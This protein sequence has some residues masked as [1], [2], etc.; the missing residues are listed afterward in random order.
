M[1]VSKVVLAKLSPTME[2]GTIVKWTK[3]EGDA[4]K[5]GDVLAEIETDKANMEMEAQGSGVLRKILVQAGGKA[6]IGTLIG[7]IAEA[8]EDIEP[9]IAKE[10]GKAGAAPKPA[11]TPAPAPAAP[12]PEPAKAAAEATAKAA[13]A[14]Q[15]AS[16]ASAAKTPPAP[17]PPAPGPA[18]APVAASAS[19]STGGDGG[20]VK[21]SPLARSMAAH[22]N[23]DLSSVAGSGPGGRII[24]RDIES[25]AGP[26]PSAAPARSS[27]APAARASSAPAPR[28]APPGPSITPGQ[29]LPLSN[30]RK[31]IAKRLSESKFGAPHYYV[32]VEIDMDAAVD[33]RDQIQ[34]L[35][36]GKVS[37]N[38]LVVKA[39]ARALTRFPMVNASWGGD[40]I[41]THADVN[42]GIAVA[43]PDGLITPVVRN[44]DRKSILDIAQEVRDL[45]TRARD[46][47]LKPEEF[48][49]S[50]FT[51]SNLGMYD[52]DSFTAIIN[53][54]DSAILAVGAVRKVPVVDGDTIRPGH[55]MKVT[56]S[57]DHRVI[58]GALAAQFLAEVRRL[59]EAP[60]GLL[61]G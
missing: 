33:L 38:D 52:V 10:A 8:N 9:L 56:M 25:W 12:A 43:I 13:P 37:F 29:E 32:T 27:G 49:G 23:I 22:Q 26:R 39:C 19:A 55:R 14:D 5:Q 24:K 30:M 36:E 28:P 60:V 15:P 1:T 4:V 61:L 7:V 20:R 50:T 57:S 21:A 17:P 58:D 40:K 34:R 11:A 47:K 46:R 2:E 51:I 54:P 3:K 31:T 6:P 53:P 44:A 35:E 59:L 48:T 42:I 45:A 41:A 18:P 16:A